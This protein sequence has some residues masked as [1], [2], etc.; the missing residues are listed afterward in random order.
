MLLRSTPAEDGVDDRDPRREAYRYAMSDRLILRS[1]LDCVDSRLPGTGVFDIKTRAAV[2]IRLDVLNYEENSGYLIKTLTGAL[3]SFEKEYY[4]L[5]RS[6]FL[7]YSFQVR[8]GNMDGVLIAYHNTARLFGFQY[9]SL[10]EMEATLYG[11]GNGTRVFNK[12]VM[13][14]EKVL[15]D[16]AG[17]YGER[18]VRCTFE[19]RERSQQLNVW[20]EPAEWDEQAEGKPCPI[21]QLDIKVASFLQGESEAVRGARA[22]ADGRAWLLHWR[23]SQS[24][25]DAVDIRANLENAQGRQ[26]RVLNF[27]A[28]IETMKEMEER[29]ES[30]NY[31]G[32]KTRTLQDLV[33]LTTKDQVEG[34][35]VSASSEGVDSGDG[36]GKEMEK[37]NID[38]HAPPPPSLDSRL[39]SPSSVF[40]TM[41]FRPANRGI[42]ML[43]QL[44]L[45]GRDETRRE[46][47]EGREKVVWG[48]ALPSCR[49][50][51]D[52]ESVEG[53]DIDG[54]PG[55]EDDL[56][57]VGGV[58]VEVGDGATALGESTVEPVIP[59]ERG[60]GHTAPDAEGATKGGV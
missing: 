12:C 35:G 58:A 3:E 7:K 44:A 60:W 17:V 29:W 51:L 6:A 2:P 36:V 28:G 32:G 59:K 14:L 30:L 43:R 39:Q 38:A 54:V 45:E 16:V 27:P 42:E 5:I 48:V 25:L 47:A 10:E 50:T 31:G 4:D 53:G 9:V 24:A 23:I 52:S 18:S 46:Q 1:Q 34:E 33:G 21:A 26:F 49:E 40:Q 55:V 8:I 57:E 19:T 41:E 56:V 22:V 11:P 37:E 20:I 15:S 13:L